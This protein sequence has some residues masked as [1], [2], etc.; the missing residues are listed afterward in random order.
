M[1]ITFSRRKDCR[2][3]GTVYSSGM[4]QNGETLSSS[5]GFR[6]LLCRLVSARKFLTRFDLFINSTGCEYANRALITRV[7][8]SN[9]VP[10]T[11]QKALMPVT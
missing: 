4:T 10:E 6:A 5:E 8:G 2:Q 9:P 11:K 1:G 3:Q 7:T